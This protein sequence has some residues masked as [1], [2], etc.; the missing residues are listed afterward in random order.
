MI[1]TLFGFLIL[2]V[3]LAACGDPAP[4]PTETA[5]YL[6]V[7][8]LYIIDP[9]G[10]RD[11]ASGFMH[12]TATGGDFR[13]IGASS[14]DAVRIELHTHDMSDGQMKMRQVE[15]FDIAAGETLVLETGGN[16]LMLFGWDEA[17]QPGDESELLLSF[18]GSDDEEVTLS[19]RAEV[20][21][22][23]GH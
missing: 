14:V 6:E 11:V 19:L 13:F 7:S 8:D 1:R 21:D 16:H 2:G 12:V 9:A 18:T 22:L 10:G 17:M 4:A 15:G 5:P 20:R 23:S 3:V